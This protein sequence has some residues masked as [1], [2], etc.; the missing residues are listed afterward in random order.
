MNSESQASR[1]QSVDLL[2]SCFSGGLVISVRKP[3]PIDGKSASVIDNILT[4]VSLHSSYIVLTDEWNP[5]FLFSK[6]FVYRGEPNANTKVRMTIDD[7]STKKLRAT[8]ACTGW[9]SVYEETDSDAMA[10]LFIVETF[11]LLLTLHALY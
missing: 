8:L 1:S 6:F 11:V 4:N 10:P 9:N 2:A 3:T 7:K 5:F